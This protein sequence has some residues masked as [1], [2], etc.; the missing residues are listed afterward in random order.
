MAY[1]YQAGQ[2]SGSHANMDDDG[3]EANSKRRRVQRACDTCR[4]KKIRCILEDDRGPCVT[5]AN[6]GLECQF[7]DSAKKRMPPRSYV[8][9]LEARMARA[10]TLLRQVAPGVDLYEQLGPPLTAENTKARAGGKGQDEDMSEDTHNGRNG[11]FASSSET[12]SN[13]PGSSDEEEGVSFLVDNLRQAGFGESSVC[14]SASRGTGSSGSTVK[15]EPL[16]DM[17]S[18]RF[19]STR[20]EKDV[21]DIGKATLNDPSSAMKGSAT[22]FGSSS[23]IN[24]FALI[25]RFTAGSFAPEIVESCKRIRDESM[26][27]ISRTEGPFFSDSMRP[28]NTID[29]SIDL[30]W[31]APEVEKRLLDA[32]FDLIHP[33]MP[34]VNEVVFREEVANRRK[35]GGE[36]T[37]NG[38]DWT[39]VALG[40]F[41]LASRVLPDDEEVVRIGSINADYLEPGLVWWHIRHRL[42]ATELVERPSL[43]Y[44]QS[45]LL[46]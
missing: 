41:A 18:R 14:T 21:D 17:R 7:L 13:E 6:L 31:P 24:I 44:I 8:D 30:C 39:C 36:A 32:Y 12:T 43:Q 38:R 16:N 9:A 10:E 42:G 35:P 45:Q 20:N 40:I 2:A 3:D 4:R 1:S 27:N 11:S 29:P 25:E 46:T 28:D 26:L 15:E 23:G 22:Y 34:I 33:N 19:I 5:C 37:S